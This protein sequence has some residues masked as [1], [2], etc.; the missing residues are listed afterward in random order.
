MHVT[1]V[2]HWFHES[3]VLTVK[4]CSPFYSVSLQTR[5]PVYTGFSVPRDSRQVP[6]SP[7]VSVVVRPGDRSSGGWELMIS[8]RLRRVTSIFTR[9]RPLRITTYLFL[10]FHYRRNTNWELKWG[11]G[12]VLFG[13]CVILTFLI[14]Q[15]RVSLLLRSSFSGFLLIHL[16]L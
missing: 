8:N 4:E 16:C 10:L 3:K 11:C 2:R 9:R 7:V 1:K 14:L 5:H 13:Q 6:W 15:W 12:V